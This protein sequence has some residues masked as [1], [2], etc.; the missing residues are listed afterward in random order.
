MADVFCGLCVLVGEITFTSEEVIPEPFRG[1]P[2]SL[3]IR[4]FLVDVAYETMIG[5]GLIFHK[6]EHCALRSCIVLGNTGK[7]FNRHGVHRTKM[8][9]LLTDF[10]IQAGHI[11]EKGL[12]ILNNTL[13]FLFPVFTHAV[14]NVD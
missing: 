9:N 13:A 6:S 11:G 12:N 5:I 14:T 7:K 8:L 2:T 10:V 3:G 4:T 1:Q